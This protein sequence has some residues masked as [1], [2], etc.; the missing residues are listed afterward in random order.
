MDVESVSS[1]DSFSRWEVPA[2]QQREHD[3]LLE[4]LQS[5]SPSGITGQNALRGILQLYPEQPKKVMVAYQVKK[6]QGTMAQK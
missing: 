4:Q 5:L 2:D 6:L 3:F 1:E